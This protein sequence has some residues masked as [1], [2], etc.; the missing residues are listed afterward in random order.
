MRQDF[1]AGSVAFWH[2][3]GS[4]PLALTVAAVSV[5]ASSN[6][7]DWHLGVLELPVSGV[8]DTTEDYYFSGV[9]VESGSLTTSVAGPGGVVVS[10]S[11]S[12]AKASSTSVGTTLSTSKTTTSSAAAT[13]SA[14]AGGTLAKWSQCA[15]E[16]WTGSGTCVAG[17]TCTYSNAWYSQC[18]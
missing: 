12:T 10:S 16:G 5:S 1:S 6:G 13:T 7:E 2:S 17:T 14:A 9:Y 8:A 4:D 3:T 11:S 18:L 15:G